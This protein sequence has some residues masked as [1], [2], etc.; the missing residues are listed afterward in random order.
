MTI[1]HAAILLLAAATG[2][3]AQ[4]AADHGTFTLIQDGR[5]IATE[6]FERSGDRLETELAVVDQA[7]LV[8]RADLNPDATIARLEVEV[9]GPG[10]A[11]GEPIQSSAVTFADGR[12]SFEEPLGTATPGDREVDA[13][14]VPYLNPSPASLEQILRRARAIGGDRVTVPIWVPG[15]D[16]GNVATAAVEFGPGTATIAFGAARVETTTDAVGRLLSARVPSQ[17]LVIERR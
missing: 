17:N 3:G 16:G 2:A 10:G 12:A 7:T 5:A 14:A 6:S 8:T 1:A 15:P 9:F 4:Q 11:A 13:G